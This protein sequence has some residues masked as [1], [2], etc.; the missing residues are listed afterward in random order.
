MGT[1]RSPKLC[2]SVKTDGKA[3][4]GDVVQTYEY[5]FDDFSNRT[6]LIAS[7]D[8]DYTATYWYDA[9]NRLLESEKDDGYTETVTEYSYDDNGNQVEKE[10]WIDNSF[11]SSET[12]VYNGFNQLVSVS[13]DD[14]D[15]EY[16]YAPSGLRLTKTVD[17]EQ[18]YYINDG[19]NVI[20]ELYEDEVTAY[21]LRGLNLY[22]SFI[23]NDEY[24]YLYNAHGDVVN[25]TDTSGYIEHT[26]RYDAFGNERE[27]DSSD[28]NPFR[29]C[30]EYYDGETGS[31]YLRARYY[32]PVVG[33]FMQEDAYWDSQNRIYDLLGITAKRSIIQS[34]NLYVYCM[35]SPL[36]FIDTSGESVV[37]A[38]RTS[39]SL[40]G[41][42]ALL[43]GPLPFG[44][45]FGLLVGISG[46]IFIGH[47]SYLAE[48]NENGDS[49]N[50]DNSKTGKKDKDQRLTGEPG[51][52]NV[53]GTTETKIGPDGR[54]VA[55]RH[56]T[57]HGKPRYHTNPH[58]HNITWDANG[59]PVFGPAIN[60]PNGA[61][62]F[63]C[64]VK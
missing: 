6:E 32:D 11:D 62:K 60:Y 29:Y 9:N 24:F 41:G 4:N 50:A 44:D 30:G 12:S 20:A 40:A 46:T 37:D 56:N 2:S 25:L 19:D 23:G 48:S 61:P 26:Y 57:D 47:Y 10:V 22:G 14:V 36:Q 45:I 5:E 1:H 3:Q 15:A 28:N 27:P 58:D 43:D 16:T 54:A 53:E 59:N 21:Y 55:E 42:I 39:W 51:D 8:E 18:I 13:N 52:I 49:T 35:N 64:E 38:L 34:G 17:N 7:G 31:Y 63:S 33:R